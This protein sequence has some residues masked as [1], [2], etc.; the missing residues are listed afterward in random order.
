MVP[1]LKNQIKK[2]QKKL[3]L[4]NLNHYR[5][6][7]SIYDLCRAIIFLSKRKFNGKINLASGKELFIKQCMT[8]ICL[9]VR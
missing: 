5:D 8:L 1:D 6:F 2:A 9:R 7:I 4:K 3:K